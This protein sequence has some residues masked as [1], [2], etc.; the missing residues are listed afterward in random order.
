M[1][2][3]RWLELNL[4][5][6]LMRDDL[7]FRGSL[8][9]LGGEQTR[10]GQVYGSQKSSWAIIVIQVREDSGMDMG[11]EQKWTEMKGFRMKSGGRS[12][13]LLI[14]WIQR[15]KGGEE[16]SRAPRFW[17]ERPEGWLRCL[18]RQG[19]LP[20]NIIY[21]RTYQALRSQI[22]KIH[23]SYKMQD[24]D[25]NPSLHKLSQNVIPGD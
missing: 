25:S 15:M 21:R 8:C 6:R 3:L 22:S 17:P 11:K 20:V 9:L 12:K 7:C 5:R 14:D 4:S 19:R 1:S 2:T 16:E 24:Q 10:K 23:V 13:S 18:S